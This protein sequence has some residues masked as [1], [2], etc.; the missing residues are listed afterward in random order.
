[1]TVVTNLKKKNS[2]ILVKY[3]INFDKTVKNYLENFEEICFYFE[4]KFQ[5]VKNK[6]KKGWI[7]LK[8]F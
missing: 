5:V 4:K 6:N 1:M 2:D 3:W 7:I 8:Q